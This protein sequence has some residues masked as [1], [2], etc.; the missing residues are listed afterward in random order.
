MTQAAERA[1]NAVD[2]IDWL[3]GFYRR[4]IGWRA[5]EREAGKG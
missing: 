2:R 1:Y 4:D 3:E 5:I